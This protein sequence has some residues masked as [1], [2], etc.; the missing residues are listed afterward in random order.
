MRISLNW[1]KS[2][3]DFDLTP[4][5]LAHSLTMAAGLEVSAVESVGSGLDQIVVGQI[6]EKAPHPDADRLSVCKVSDGAET[7]T[8]VCGASNMAAN[9]KVAFAKAGTTMPNGLSIK[10]AEIRGAASSGMLCS[11]KELG[12]SEESSGLLILPQDIPAGRSLPDALGLPDTV[13]ELELTPNRPDCLSVVGVARDVAAITGCEFRLPDP[14][15]PETGDSVENQASLEIPAPDLCHR[16]AARVIK[17]VKIGPSPLWL[18]ARLQSCGLRSINNVVDATNYVLMEMGHPLHAFDLQKLAGQKIIVKRAEKG[19]KFTTL[20]G[21]ERLLDDEALVICDAQRPVALAGIMG[22]QNSEV[23]DDTTD[24]LLESAYFLPSSIRRTARKLG[25]STDSSYRFERGADIEGMMRSLNQCAKLIVELAGGQASKGVI[26]S[27]VTQHK[28]PQ[29]SLR[30][31]KIEAVLGVAVEGSEAA[32]LMTRLGA[33]IVQ[34]DEEALLVEV[35]THRPDIEREIDLI[36][37]VARLRGYDT[38]PE[39]LPK[40]PMAC[41]PA[42]KLSTVSET[43]RNILAALGFRE[44]VTLSFSDSADFDKMGYADDSPFRK[45]IKLENPLNAETELLRTSLLPGLLKAAS[46]NFRRQQKDISLFESGRTFHRQNGNELPNEKNQLA[47][48]L[49]GRRRPLS[50]CNNRDMVDFFDIKGTIENLLSR[51]GVPNLCFEPASGLEW[52]HPGRGAT[53]KSGEKT[54]GVLGQI[55]P[56]SSENFE[57]SQDVFAFD[58][59][60][61]AVAAATAG[62]SKIKNQAKYPAVERDL[63]FL[64]DQTISAGNLQDVILSVESTLIRSATLFDVYKGERLPPGKASLAFRLVYRSDEKTL[65]EQEADVLDARIIR[66]VN[67]KTGADLRKA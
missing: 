1:L 54:L 49:T 9:D 5:E 47:G 32:T 52:L 10:K 59:D 58:L 31:K 50:W 14:E 12:L 17:G 30:L 65:T 19:T 67:E 18:K 13:L 16:Y 57:I 64:V 40:I 27:Y 21:Q 60:L 3:V 41:D 25:L 62:I 6:L 2:Y 42:P 28:K 29:V 22:G 48:I 38:I 24:I 39:T 37:E 45:G 35:P 36:E 23:Q 8:V 55:H 63:A 66:V 46:T 56:A 51:L 61:D 34:Q 44:A 15:V 53:I 11:A 43:A 4:E 7:F 33:N 26:D 20:D